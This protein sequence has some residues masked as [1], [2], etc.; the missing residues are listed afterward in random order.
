MNF[1][2]IYVVLYFRQHY[3]FV[4]EKTNLQSRMEN[5]AV[6]AKTPLRGAI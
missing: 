1:Y 4:S 5:I 2:N 3:L 6:W